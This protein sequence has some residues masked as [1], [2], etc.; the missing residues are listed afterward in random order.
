L[1]KNEGTVFQFSPYE[2]STLNQIKIQLEKSAEP[3]KNI[4]ISFIKTLT[5]PPTDRNYKGQIWEPSR[6]MVDLCKIIKAYYYNPYTKGSNSIKAILPAIF[7]TS[8]YIKKKYSQK[9]G[10]INMTSKNFKGNH[11][12]LTEQNGEIIDPY[13]I[14]EKPFKDWN[15]EFQRKSTIEE[16][17]DG[18]AAMIAYGLTQYTDM[19]ENERENIK[20]ALLKYCE[21]DTLA[22]VMVFEHLKEIIQ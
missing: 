18:G 13:K 1:D 14:L 6:G 8:S 10:N 4:L 15:P 20:K 11:I 7:K 3:D 9:L 22:M 5:T 16:I 19:S 12:W 21:L 17:N 2:N